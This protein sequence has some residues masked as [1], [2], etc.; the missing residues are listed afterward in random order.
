MIL[1]NCFDDLEMIQIKAI[2]HIILMIN[3]FENFYHNMVIRQSSYSCNKQDCSK[4]RR[5]SFLVS[6][7]EIFVPWT[8]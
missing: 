4:Y 5:D 7:L 8:G 1:Q 6:I 2:N 3:I